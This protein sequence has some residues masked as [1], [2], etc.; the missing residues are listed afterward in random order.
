[1]LPVFAR[2]AGIGCLLV[3][4]LACSIVPARSAHAQITNCISCGV[5]YK[6][7]VTPDGLPDTL[8]LANSG[9]FAVT[10]TIRNAGDS[11]DTYDLSCSATGPVTCGSLSQSFVHLSPFTETPITVHYTTGAPGSGSLTLHAT[12]RHQPEPVSDQGNFLVT[13]VGAP[14]VSLVSPVL[15]S[16]N[17]AVVRT[18]QPLIRA[19]FTPNGSPVDS[20]ATVVQWRGATITGL[21]RANRGLVEWE[22]DS[23]RRLAVGDSALISVTACAGGGVACTTVTRY[24]V[25]LNDQ[26]PVL[27]FTGAPLEAL[28]SEFGAPFGPGMSVSGAEL[29]AGFATTPYFSMGSARSFG[30]T[31]STRQSYPRALVPVDLELPWPAGT[32]SQISSSCST[33]SR[34]LILSSSRPPP[35]QPEPQS[36]AGPC[37]RATSPRPPSRCPRV[38]G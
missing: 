19:L 21:A 32:P 12:G 29:E 2:P 5:P 8:R 11:T 25:L 16:G 1:V 35:V 7:E 14:A 17:R 37:C 34:G 26:K 36:A 6:V 13:S 23:T 10:F 15:T 28:G 27:G 18:R 30:L 9:P 38:S 3:A 31:Y 24:A 20:T 33:G 4:I 22:V